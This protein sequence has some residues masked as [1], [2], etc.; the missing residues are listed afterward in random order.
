[1]DRLTKEELEKAI[2][3]S[4]RKKKRLFEQRRYAEGKQAQEEHDKI[5]EAY[6]KVLNNELR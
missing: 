6:R 5:I 2:I 3:L 4:M 1:M